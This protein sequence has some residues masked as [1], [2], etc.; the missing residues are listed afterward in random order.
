MQ[1]INCGKSRNV[2]IQLGGW[3]GSSC[4]HAGAD[5]TFYD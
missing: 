2:A 3:I 1:A 4:D 5:V